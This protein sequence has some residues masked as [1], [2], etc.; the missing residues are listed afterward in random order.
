MSKLGLTVLALLTLAIIGCEKEIHN[1][2]PDNGQPLQE[3]LLEYLNQCEIE[4]FSGSVLIQLSDSILIQQGYGKSNRAEN[5]ENSINTIFD[6]GSVTKQ[7]TAS[8]ILKLEMDELIDLSNSIG[9]HVSGLTNEKSALTIHQLLTHTSGLQESVGGDEEQISKND[10]IVRVNQT[11]LKHTPGEKYRYSNIGYSLLGIL[12]EEV[13]S[14]TY[15]NY[16]REN[17]FL[18]AGMSNTGYII[19]NWDN[20]NLA[21]GYRKKRGYGSPIDQNWNEEGPSWH[22]K[23]N[24]GIL[25]NVNDMYLWHKALLDNTIINEEAKEMMYSK[26][27]NEGDNTSFYGYGWAIF[28]TNRGTDLITHNGGNDYFFADFLRF[29]N[30]DVVIIILSNDY[31]VYAQELSSQLRRIIFE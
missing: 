19:P 27:T 10:F 9:T 24:G 8:A 23:G 20:E 28:P 4:G 14:M 6:I 5:I 22:M 2:P 11:N 16:V 21:L 26:H 13:S 1:I 7:F 25:T 30:E 12:I 3:R 18:P 29:I 31:N 15:E 17:L